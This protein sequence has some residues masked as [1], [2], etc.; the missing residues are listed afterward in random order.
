M[1][2]DAQYMTLFEIV[3]DNVLW[4]FFSDLWRNS[5]VMDQQIFCSEP[6]IRK[7]RI[8]IFC[9][10]KL[11]RDFFLQ[12]NPHRSKP[13]SVILSRRTPPLVRPCVRRAAASAPWSA[14]CRCTQGAASPCTTDQLII[15]FLILSIYYLCYLAIYTTLYYCF[16]SIE[17]SGPSD[18]YIRVLLR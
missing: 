18:F 14:P 12:F 4:R 17:K 5:I 13:V 3:I 15:L 16:S 1:I 8:V 7:G 11:R 9:L 6:S 10:Y 2:Y